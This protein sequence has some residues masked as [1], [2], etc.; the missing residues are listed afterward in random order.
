MDTPKS[1][2]EVAEELK[3]SKSQAK[4]WLQRLVKEGV[5]KIEFDAAVHHAKLAVYAATTLADLLFET[6]N[7]QHQRGALGPK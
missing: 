7:Y 2:A 4:E 3:V 1:D 6:K 5:I